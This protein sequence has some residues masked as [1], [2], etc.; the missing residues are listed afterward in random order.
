[1]TYHGK[2]DAYGLTNF[3]DKG[4]KPMI[5]NQKLKSILKPKEEI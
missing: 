1:M 4:E 3:L 5:R 2:S